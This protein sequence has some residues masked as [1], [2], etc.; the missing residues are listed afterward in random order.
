MAVW[1]TFRHVSLVCWAHITR[2]CFVSSARNFEGLKPKT[3]FIFTSLPLLWRLFPR[4]VFSPDPQFS[5]EFSCTLLLFFRFILSIA[6]DP[7][8]PSFRNFF[9]GVCRVVESEGRLIYFGDLIPADCV[10]RRLSEEL[11]ALAFLAIST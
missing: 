5:G 3:L 6:L 4:C 8:Y 2:W 11:F 7:L 10:L 1:L 9:V